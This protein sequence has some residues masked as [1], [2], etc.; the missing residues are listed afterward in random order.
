MVV[1]RRKEKESTVDGEWGQRVCIVNTH[2]P[3]THGGRSRQIVLVNDQYKTKF[4]C[5][6][7][8]EPEYISQVKRSK[9]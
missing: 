7:H 8:A 3:S 9:K 6:Q 5:L 2:G 4:L 1:A